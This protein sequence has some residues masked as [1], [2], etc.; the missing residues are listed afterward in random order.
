MSYCW[1]DSSVALHWIKGGGD[2][3]QFCSNRVRKIQEKEYLQCRHVSI[4]ENRGGKISKCSGC[5]VAW[6]IVAS[7][8]S[9]MARKYCY[10]IYRGN[11]SRSQHRERASECVCYNRWPTRADDAKMGPG[12]SHPN[13][14]VGGAICFAHQNYALA[15]NHWTNHHIRDNQTITILGTK[16]TRRKSEHNQIW[17]R[18]AAP[19][20]TKECSRYIRVQRPCPG[21]LSNLST[22]WC[23][24]CWE[25]RHARSPPNLAWGRWIDSGKR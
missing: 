5:L 14:F 15:D 22:W 9:Q 6:A 1:L 17:G 2:Y 20:P 25:A 18:Q 4:K 10:H 7:V 21:S 12:E 11:T 16:I 3:K 19:Q 8:P 24:I 13:L 23:C